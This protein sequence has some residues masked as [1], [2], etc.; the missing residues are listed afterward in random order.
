MLKL[1]GAHIRVRLLTL[2]SHW[3][4]LLGELIQPALRAL[5]LVL[6]LGVVLSQNQG[7]RVPISYVKQYVSLA[8][9]F[10]VF[11]GFNNGAAIAE[12]VKSGDIVYDLVRPRSWFVQLLSQ[13]LGER[14][15][16]S[17]LPLVAFAVISR[18][19]GLEMGVSALLRLLA[20]LPMVLLLEFSLTLNIGIAT[21][22]TQNSWGL[23]LA[24][25][26]VQNLLS[27]ILVP[28]FVMP[29][30]WT[31]AAYRTPFP[32]LVDAPI[33]VVTGAFSIHD[34]Y[35]QQSIWVAGLF[36]LAGLLYRVAVRRLSI[37]GG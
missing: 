12:R 24:F 32:L 36:A 4:T 20:T 19:L 9:F 23:G 11:L 13:Y 22:W 18:A 27:G 1:T 15:A 25:G 3:V 14:V 17:V 8:A 26:W 2:F 34:L 35:V 5:I 21:L 10:V 31:V 7:A 30:R 33:R 16:S 28:L 29:S 6:L 37:N